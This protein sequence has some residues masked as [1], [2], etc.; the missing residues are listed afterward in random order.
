LRMA[1]LRYQAL[2]DG[3]ELFGPWDSRFFVHFDGRY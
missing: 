3:A 1:Y 2:S